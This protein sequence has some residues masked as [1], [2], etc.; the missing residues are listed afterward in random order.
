[1]KLGD[2][3]TPYGWPK[4]GSR[5]M[6][7]TEFRN[8]QKTR[9]TFPLVPMELGASRE[10]SVVAFWDLDRSGCAQLALL[11]SSASNIRQKATAPAG[12][13]SDSARTAYSDAALT[14]VESGP[15]SWPLTRHNG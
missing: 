15:N 13:V 8:K 7:V 3:K 9:R 2:A 12:Q 11:E 6:G 4:S 5:A 14:D 10:A 1:M